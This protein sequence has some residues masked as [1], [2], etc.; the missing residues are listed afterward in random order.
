[1]ASMQWIPLWADPSQLPSAVRRLKSPLRR[2]LEAVKRGK[3]KVQT[4]VIPF[5]EYE[6][7][8]NRS[9]EASDLLREALWLSGRLDA[10]DLASGG[11]QARWKPNSQQLVQVQDDLYHPLWAPSFLKLACDFLLQL[12][13]LPAELRAELETR[14]QLPEH[15]LQHEFSSA[16][17][18]EGTASLGRWFEWASQ[19]YPGI[20][21]DF[22]VLVGKSKPGMRAFIAE[23]EY[24][25]AILGHPSRPKLL[26][27]FPSGALHALPPPN[28]WMTARVIGVPVQ[29]PAPQPGLPGG[30]LRAIALLGGVAAPR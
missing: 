4:P 11:G 10:H 12:P 3:L 13:K 28:G 2:F 1:M 25:V 7:D 5:L 9:A 24:H 16:L 30:G 6:L 15:A 8:G 17:E 14:R 21:E 18:R 20:D 19:T 26:S 29:A 23:Q 22:K 27:Y